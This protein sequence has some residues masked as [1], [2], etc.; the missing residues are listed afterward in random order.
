[1]T[2]EQ[3]LRMIR[4]MVQGLAQRLE[5]HPDD[6]AGWERLAHAYEVLGEG[7]KAQAARARAAGN[8]NGAR[9]GA[10]PAASSS[11][12]SAAAPAAPAS[13]R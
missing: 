10:P 11:A 8:P 5:Q 9:G 6:K 4:G 1:M 12:P 2:P 7:D 13:P 3:R